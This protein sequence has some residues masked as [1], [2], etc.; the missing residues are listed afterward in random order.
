MNCFDCASRGRRAEAVAV[1]TGC[2]AG[3]CEEH[4]HVGARWLYTT[5]VINRLVR[6]EPPTR[7]ILCG[8]CQQAHDAAD[9]QAPARARARA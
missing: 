2:G 1:C 7:V 9:G 6:V 8:L 5:A 4:A 3:V